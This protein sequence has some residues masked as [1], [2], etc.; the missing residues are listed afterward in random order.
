[1]IINDCVV[2]TITK[3]GIHAEVIDENGSVPVTVFVA[4]DHHFNDNAFSKIN[5]ND[6]IKVTCWM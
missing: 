6:K 3:A 1:M 5:V 4:R 2:K